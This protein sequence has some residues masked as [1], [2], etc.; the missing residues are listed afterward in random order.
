MDFILRFNRALAHQRHKDLSANHVDI[1]E[2]PVLKL[3]LEMEKQMAEIY[4]RRI[5]YKFQDELWHSLVTMPQIVNE[6]DTLK[7]Y[8]VQS[9]PNGGV[10]R[11]REI[12]YDKV[13]DYASCNCKK[14]E[15]EGIPCRHILAFLQFFGD[16][17]LLNQ[18]IMK[19]WTRAAKSQIIYD[20]EGLEISGK[21][22][23]MLT[24]RSKLFKLFSELVDNIMLNEEAAVIVNDALQSLVD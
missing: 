5:F 8:T 15:R 1:N 20:K 3:P 11:F 24:W 9:C 16:I 13:L 2:K 21:C 4:T 12:P 19:K 23:S 18:C 22:S 7:M 17:P 6:N 14:F 10:P